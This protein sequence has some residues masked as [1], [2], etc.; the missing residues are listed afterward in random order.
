[1]LDGAVREAAGARADAVPQVPSL[2]EVYGHLLDQHGTDFAT[3]ARLVARPAD[4]E[5]PAVLVHCTAGKDRT[6]VA[7]ALLLDA[8]GASRDAIID[9]YLDTEQNLSGEWAQ[10]MRARIEAAGIPLSDEIEV[11]LART[12]RPAIESVFSR[13]DADGGTAEYL[14]RHGLS[15]ADLAALRARL[16]AA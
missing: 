8:A 4:T 13:L 7:V 11:L 3:V 12:P 5:R 16:R 14:L 9:D 6:G 1:M 2:T 15:A 10:A